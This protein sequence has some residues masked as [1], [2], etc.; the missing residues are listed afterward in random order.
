MTFIA[1][2]SRFRRYIDA[3][4]R[5]RYRELLLLRDTVRNTAGYLEPLK[6]TRHGYSMTTEHL[7][8]TLLHHHSVNRGK[9]N[10]VSDDLSAYTLE[11]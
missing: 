5:N 6:G 7:I 1:L 10:Y 11:I 3:R 2:L 9:Q 4:S 8:V